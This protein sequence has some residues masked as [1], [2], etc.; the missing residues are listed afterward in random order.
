MRKRFYL[1][2][3]YHFYAVFFLICLLIQILILGI[4]NSFNLIFE[5]WYVFAFQILVILFYFILGVSDRFII[6]SDR[7]EYWKFFKKSTYLFDENKFVC[8]MGNTDMKNHGLFFGIQFLPS[9][10]DFWIKPKTND[11]RSEILNSRHFEMYIT[12]N[13]FYRFCQT[14]SETM[15]QNN[16]ETNLEKLNFDK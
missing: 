13:N 15:I 12:R 7:I 1:N 10:S 11:R 3:R 5:V 4:L 9:H 2:G 8:K 6:K 16:S 14:L